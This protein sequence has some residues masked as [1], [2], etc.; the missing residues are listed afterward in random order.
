MVRSPRSCEGTPLK[1]APTVV[2]ARTSLAVT[3]RIRTAVACALRLHATSCGEFDGSRHTSGATASR[4]THR[5]RRRSWG[6]ARM[7]AGDA[8]VFLQASRRLRWQRSGQQ[9]VRWSPSFRRGR[10]RQHAHG[11]SRCSRYSE[12]APGT[13]RSRVK[14]RTATSLRTLSRPWSRQLTTLPGHS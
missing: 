10:A 8:C 6:R 12:V 11:Q 3:T 4:C 9:V 14:R 1:L 5:H 2:Y 7:K 13:Y